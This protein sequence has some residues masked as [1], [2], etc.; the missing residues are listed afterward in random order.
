[1]KKTTVKPTKINGNEAIIIE[2]DNLKLISINIWFNEYDVMGHK[3]LF[4]EFCPDVKVLQDNYKPEQYDSHHDEFSLLEYEGEKYI[5][6]SQ[7]IDDMNSVIVGLYPFE[8]NVFNPDS[9][10]QVFNQF[11]GGH[12]N[13]LKDILGIQYTV[14]RN[15]DYIIIYSSDKRAVIKENF[16]D[17]SEDDITPQVLQVLK[18]FNVKD[19]NEKEKQKQNK[20][21]EWWEER[22]SLVINGEK[23]LF[24]L[25]EKVIEYSSSYKFQ[26]LNNKDVEE[27]GKVLYSVIYS[28]KNFED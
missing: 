21:L 17:F 1:M 23:Y 13:V 11:G 10:F 8:N 19:L 14:L 3:R 20:P 9:H 27:F 16:I 28:I 18:D 25:D 22:Y 15:D 2:K 24:N 6:W 5:G 4:E 7:D 12:S 26:K